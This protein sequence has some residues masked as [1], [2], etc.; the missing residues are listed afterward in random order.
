[1][2]I[3]QPMGF[4]ATVLGA[5]G[6]AGGELVRLLANHPALSLV[7]AGAHSS[8][9]RSIGS[10]LPALR[11]T[12]GKLVT[13]EQAAG[14]PADVCFSCLP[15][16]ALADHLD[17]VQAGVIVDLSGDHRADESWVY[18][19]SEF[20]R[21]DLAKAERVANPGCY[22]T[23]T[24]LALTPFLT[25][26]LISGP[27]VVDA[28][29]G[30]SGA[31]RKLEDHLLFSTIHASAGAYGS[32]EH[33]HVP[34]MERG[35]RTFGG[36]APVVSFTPHLIPLA[37]GLLVT[38]RAPLSA[39]LTSTAALDVLEAAYLSEPFVHVGEE[40]PAT[41]D[42]S[43]TNHAHVSARVDERAG[44]LIASATI[45]NLGKGAAGQAIQNANIALGVE[46]TAGLEAMALWP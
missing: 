19:L 20:A 33:R 9:G 13:L 26:G 42:V 3:M 35:L 25:R 32:T 12:T 2:H 45:D 27:I 22:P 10:V 16:G 7:G 18:G 8:H 17:S 31:G 23:A 24:L 44:F 39:P 14:T 6:Y 15:E 5:S 4:G 40:W 30:T 28:M 41:K 36:S 29:S 46:E 1:M 43:G 11:S 34:E 37:R 38:A 21:D